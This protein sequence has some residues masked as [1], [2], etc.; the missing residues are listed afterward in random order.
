MRDLSSTGAE[1]SWQE[2]CVSGRTMLRRWN[3]FRTRTAGKI[4]ICLLGL[5]LLPMNP[6]SAAQSVTFGWDPSPDANAVGYNIYFGT[7]S[8][9]Y[10]NK[11]SVGNV[12]T[13][14]VG[15]LVE[16][17]TYYFAATT[18]DTL[19][20][21]SSFCDEI[22]Y[23]VP[24]SPTNQPPAI[25]TLQA[26]NQADAGASFDFVVTATGT[27]PL[28]YQWQFNGSNLLSAT[29][30]VLSFSPVV[31]AQAGDYLVIV[32]NIFGS[33]TSAPVN[34]AVYETAP[35]LTLLPAVNDHFAM[36]VS[37][38]PSY[39]YIVQASTN[40]VNW[41]SIG[42]NTSPF[43][44]VDTD[45]S[46][47]TSRFYR[48]Y[49][50][51][52]G[53]ILATPTNIPPSIA[54]MLATNVAT[55]GQN[56]NFSVTAAG[57]G[58]LAYQWMF[59]GTNIIAATNAILSLNNVTTVQS[60]N[61]S[62]V[63]TNNFGSITSAT[64]NLVI[65]L[66]VAVITPVSSINGQFGLSIV[67]Q[68]GYQYV[69]QA[70][71]NLVNWVSI[72]TNISPFEFVDADTS[73]FQQRFYRTYFLGL[74]VTNLVNDVTDGLVAYY[75]LAANGNDSQSGNNLTLAGFPGFSAG[76]VN[77]NGAVPTLGYSAPRQW[78]QA[79]VTVSAW[80]NMADPSANYIVA[81]CYGDSSGQL[82]QAYMQF[83]TQNGRLNA[84]IV[85]HVDADY[86]GRVTPANLTTGWH[87]A[88]F[89]WT[90]GT[91]SG[92]IKIYLDGVP[93]DNADANGGNFTGV[94]SGADLPFTVGAQFSDGWGISGKFFGSQKGVRMYDHA[95]TP[96]DIH[97]LHNNGTSGGNF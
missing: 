70:S 96:E 78:P 88:A 74:P 54:S 24:E 45:S 69:V 47:Y 87:F 1:S 61:Y 77:W 12:T 50:P 56:L 59:N 8:H 76:A 18:Y 42:T 67:G 58:P 35:I 75:P 43:D 30:S 7:S 5:F 29:N 17:V 39:H 95:L 84:R 26:T 66:A 33:I 81:A 83:F 94:Y 51:A 85:Q 49:L 11:V 20:L 22:A 62:V 92:S 21:E 52:P 48:A 82:Q 64:V 31:A 44:F 71:T 73:R 68:P 10:T 60:G 15:G 9:I 89:T 72:A 25:T 91:D 86:I 65:S 23:T 27:G 34:L 36:N 41:V 6:L 28:A 55:L 38:R 14:A 97:Q 90:G 53:S 80:I 57:T 4:L 46:I 13:A 3:I 2:F 37:G 93:V 79:G 32:A 16:G 63:V 40:L 19:N